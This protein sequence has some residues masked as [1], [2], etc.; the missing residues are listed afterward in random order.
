MY[1]TKLVEGGIRNATPVDETVCQQIEQMSNESAWMGWKY[2]PKADHTGP[3]LSFLTIIPYR[4]TVRQAW[5]GEGFHRFFETTF[6]SAP[7]SA[8][9]MQ[10]LRMLVLKE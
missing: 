10:G 3:E 2:I 1:G 9:V 4:T 6:E 7:T 8:E 5:L